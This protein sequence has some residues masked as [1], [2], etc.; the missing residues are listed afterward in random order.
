MKSSLLSIIKA[1]SAQSYA[2]IWQIVKD[3][4]ANVL[5]KRR[6]G[7]MLFLDDLPYS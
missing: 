3:T 6:S 1:E 4:V 2:Q 7:M 5:G